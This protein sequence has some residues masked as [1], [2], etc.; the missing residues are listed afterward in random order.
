M[1]EALSED[2]SDPTGIRTP[3]SAVRGLCPRPLDDGAECFDVGERS[4]AYAEQSAEISRSR[5]C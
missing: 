1:D 3:V 2:P 4:L 5:V